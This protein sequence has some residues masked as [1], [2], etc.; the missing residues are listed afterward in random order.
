MIL[1]STHIYIEGIIVI[2]KNF[3]II[4]DYIIKEAPQRAV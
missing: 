1:N 4:L 3:L 2:I